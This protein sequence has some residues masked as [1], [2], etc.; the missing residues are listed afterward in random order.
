MPVSGESVV[1]VSGAWGG[2]E[3][4]WSPQEER[5]ANAERRTYAASAARQQN[6]TVCSDV[7]VRAT[8]RGRQ[9]CC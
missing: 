5:R 9:C 1:V 2:A 7:C 3:P 8:G 6:N 4:S